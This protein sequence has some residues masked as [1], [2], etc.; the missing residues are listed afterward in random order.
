LRSHVR[1]VLGDAPVVGHACQCEHG[2]GA[3]H[4]SCEPDRTIEVTV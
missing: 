4:V 2:Q 3:E 1:A